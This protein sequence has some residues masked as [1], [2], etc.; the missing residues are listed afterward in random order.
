M[1]VLSDQTVKRIYQKKG[2]S[3]IAHVISAA[4]CVYNNFD[5]LLDEDKDEN[6]L[7]W[8]KDNKHT[9]I[10]NH[11]PVYLMCTHNE[12]SIL[13]KHYKD[14]PYSYVNIIDNTIYVT[15]DY[16][17][18]YE[19]RWEKDMKYEVRCTPYHN[20]TITL[21]IITNRMQSLYLNNIDNSV[22][23]T[24]QPDRYVFNNDDN[25]G[26]TF[27]LP[28]WINEHTNKKEVIEWSNTIQDVENH[29]MRLYNYGW[30]ARQCANMLSGDCRCIMLITA[31]ISSFE[32]FI[33]ENVNHNEQLND[34]I[35]KISNILEKEKEKVS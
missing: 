1:N 22:I 5:D 13:L 34:I 24:E 27:I 30:D 10:F 7:R 29:Y 31:P 14:N 16:S 17:V 19:N 18:I 3:G 12:N 32:K 26:L 35:K 23:T 15:T 4:W 11:A 33:N 9:H 21:Y 25:N 8:L 6:V 2:I 28:P 20:H